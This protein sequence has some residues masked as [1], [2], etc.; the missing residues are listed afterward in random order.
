VL[1]YFRQSLNVTREKLPKRLLYKKGGH[2][3][4]MKLTAGCET[5][6]LPRKINQ[7]VKIKPMK[8]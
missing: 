8:E 6:E 1:L 7:K 5:K 3:T 4:L 2:K